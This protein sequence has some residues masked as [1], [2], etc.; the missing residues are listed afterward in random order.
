MSL[1][2]GGMADSTLRVLVAGL[3]FGAGLPAL[4]AGGVRLW[5]DGSGEVS[6]DGTVVRRRNPLLVAAAYVVFALIVVVIAL[7]VLWIT[8]KSLDHYFGWQPFGDAK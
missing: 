6:A 2:W 1:D 4:F 5:S 3:I 8:R 7:A